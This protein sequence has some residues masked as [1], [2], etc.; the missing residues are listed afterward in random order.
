MKYFEI[1]Q[2]FESSCYLNQNTPYLLFAKSLSAFFKLR[3]LLV[4]IPTICKLH[5][6]ANINNLVP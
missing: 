4:Q 6:D 2:R 3:N 5:H 1:M